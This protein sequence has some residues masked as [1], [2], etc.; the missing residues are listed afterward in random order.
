M[1]GMTRF[2]LSLADAGT[3]GCVYVSG[4]QVQHLV[5]TQ[6]IS[7]REITFFHAVEFLQLGWLTW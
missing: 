4:Y 7:K 6:G 5:L 3:S 2:I 1:E